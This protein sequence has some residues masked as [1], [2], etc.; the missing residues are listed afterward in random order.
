MLTRRCCVVH[1][2]A[3]R[4]SLIFRSVENCRTARRQWLAAC[5][6]STPGVAQLGSQIPFR[7][8][9]CRQQIGAKTRRKRSREQLVAI[10]RR[11]NI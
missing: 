3:C 10:R 1:A 11:H 9:A 2:L 5:A 6:S 8:H 4:L 7:V